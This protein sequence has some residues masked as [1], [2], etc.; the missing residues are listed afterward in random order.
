[1]KHLP[2]IIAASAEC[3]ALNVPK[4]EDQESMGQLYN[5]MK[6]DK[7]MLKPKYEHPVVLRGNLL[8]HA[9]LHRLTDQLTFVRF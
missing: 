5:K 8:L 1:M 3:R 2:E 7:L 9:H 4:L 6:T